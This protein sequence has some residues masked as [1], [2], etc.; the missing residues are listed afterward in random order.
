MIK[1]TYTE[2]TINDYNVRTTIVNVNITIMV[3]Q[4]DSS[5]PL[6]WGRDVNNTHYA[7]LER[8][9]QQPMLNVIVITDDD[10]V[11]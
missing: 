11:C 10:A 3:A 9:R 5:Y 6:L 7:A 1:L 2:T 8:Q 4:R